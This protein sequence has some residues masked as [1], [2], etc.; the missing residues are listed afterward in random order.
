MLA[1]GSDHP[2]RFQEI[3]ATV[4]DWSAMVEGAA[5]EGVL[6]ILERDIGRSG[7]ALP[8]DAQ[9]LMERLR[10]SETLWQRHVA[11]TLDEALDALDAEDV[12]A[13]ALKGPALAERLYS[14]PGLRWSTDLDILVA[15]ADTDRAVAA[16]ERLGYAVEDQLAAG[17]ARRYH[18]HL[19]LF[20][21]RPPVLELHFRAYV[22]FGVTMAAEDLLERARPHR[23]AGGARCLVLA[24]ED[25]ALYLAVHAAGHCCDRLVWLYDLKLLAEREP[26][27]DWERLAVRARAAGVLAAF[28]L[29]RDV[30]ALRLGV[31]MPL[32][33]HAP[34]RIRRHIVRGLIDG[35]LA[36]PGPGPLSTLRQLIVMAALCDRFSASARFVRH[37]VARLARRRARRWLPALTPAEWA[38]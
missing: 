27:L 31:V 19:H 17:Y 3:A 15:H 29:V 2:D 10:A 8:A 36:P 1:A 35:R 11:R 37:H 21:R 9:R 18:H 25:E 7:L 38:A 24:P 20:R 30:L 34:G 16:L 12:R 6:G 33:A 23:T 4:S 28:A 32:V 5:R 13:A 22:G 26:A 14:D